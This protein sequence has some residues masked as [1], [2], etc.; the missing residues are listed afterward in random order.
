MKKSFA[1][2]I[3]SNYNV[4]I[5]QFILDSLQMPSVPSN[6]TVMPSL[7]SAGAASITDVE[8]EDSSDG[9]NGDSEEEV[10]T[11]VL[12]TSNNA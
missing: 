9:S 8:K 6:V 7:V 5:P 4:L 10:D 1:A 3:V 12:L 11:R 2:I